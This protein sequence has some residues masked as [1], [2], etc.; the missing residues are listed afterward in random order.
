MISVNS[1]RDNVWHA[2][3]P[4]FSSTPTDSPWSHS[5]HLVTTG[6]RF[7]K[8]NIDWLWSMKLHSFGIY[9]YS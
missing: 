4:L 3:I 5:S 1:N 2:L 8:K 7:R 9:I 6:Y